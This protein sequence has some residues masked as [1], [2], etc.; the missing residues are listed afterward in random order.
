[1]RATHPKADAD[2]EATKAGATGVNPRLCPPRTR[3]RSGPSRLLTRDSVVTLLSL[4]LDP[5]GR[6]VTAS[7]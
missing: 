1:V 7:Y 3:S 4:S 5:S 2:D 6:V